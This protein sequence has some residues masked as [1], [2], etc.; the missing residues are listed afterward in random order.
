[1][2]RLVLALVSVL[3]FVA[4]AHAAEYSR[5]QAENSR[6]GFA[7]QQMGVPMEGSF[8]KFA[9]RLSFDPTAPTSARVSIDVD[10]ASIDTGFEDGDDEVGRETWLN[11]QAFP[12][13]HFESSAVK[14][15]GDNKYELAGKL[16]IK[17]TTRDVLVPATFTAQGGLGVFD[18]SLRIQRGDFSIG[19][20][21][22]KGFDIVANDVVITFHITVAAD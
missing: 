10:L 6:I 12:T 8:S 20:G 3:A 1:M 17:G 4:T 13:A 5:V 16:T 15:L 9:S 19:E 22:W 7:Y 11:T 18:G 2:K 21:G 14:A